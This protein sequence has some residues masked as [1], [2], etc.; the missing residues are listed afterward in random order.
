MSS[1]P[2]GI[3][4]TPRAPAISSSSSSPATPFGPVPG[5]DLTRP[6]VPPDVQGMHGYPPDNDPRMDGTLLLWRYPDPLGAKDLGP[7]STLQIE[8][9]VAHLL[10][11]APSPLAKAPPFIP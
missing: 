10:G 4:T 2:H 11:I 9:T 1:P 6:S 3:T 5:N 7:V 8:P